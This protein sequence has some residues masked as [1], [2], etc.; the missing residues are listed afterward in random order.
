[1]SDLFDKLKNEAWNEDVGQRIATRAATLT[2]DEIRELSIC[3]RRF[4][5]QFMPRLPDEYRRVS[6]KEF[7]NEIQKASRIGDAADKLLSLL[8]LTGTLMRMRMTVEEGD[9]L[10]LVL[11]R[12]IE[13]FVQLRIDPYDCNPTSE[14]SPIMQPSGLLQAKVAS[15]AIN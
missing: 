2:P 9:P 4:L 8:Q 13:L 10:Q 12:S 15:E 11:M 3:L 6:F 14:I 5:K 1:M 7:F